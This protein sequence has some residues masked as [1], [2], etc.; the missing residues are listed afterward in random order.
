MRRACLPA[1]LLA[2]ILVA[3][4][5][6]DAATRYDPSLRF[7]VLRTAH[8]VI[9]FHQGEDR[10]ARRLASIAETTRTRLSER[11]GLPAPARTHVVL[12][13]Q[14][15]NSNGWATPVPY[16][17]IEITAAPPL[18]ESWLGNSDDWL[19]LAFAHEYTH[20][21]H[22]DRAEGGM[23]LL[24]A[25]LGR[26]PVTFPN[27]FLP[28]WQIEGLPT[29]AESAMT[30]RGRLGAGDFANVMDQAARRGRFPSIDRASGGLVS[31][32]GGTAPYLYGGFF[33]AYLADRYGESRF[34]EL[35]RRTAGRLPFFGGAAFNRTYGTSAKDAW[36]DFAR[37]RT[38]TAARA[39]GD[40]VPLT[41][42]THHG[43]AVEAPRFA[44]PMSGDA[45]SDEVW[46]G[47][48]TPDGFPGLHRVSLDTGRSRRVADRYLG[49]GLSVSD[50][51]V[52]FDQ[53]EV[54]RAVSLVGDLYALDRV[55]GRTWRLTRGARMSSPDVS[56]D[57]RHL[58]VV[59]SQ[60]GGRALAV[61]VLH[62][63]S[64]PNA[65]PAPD[66]AP[67]V[68][69]VEPG[70]QYGGPRWSPDGARL[71]AERQRADGTSEIVI[72]DP[73]TL[74]VHVVVSS[75]RDRNVTPT[76][77]PDG[78]SIVFAATRDSDP[79]QLYRVDIPAPHATTA[80]AP[81]RLFAT[82]H[83]ATAPALSPDGRTVVFVGVTDRGDDL[84]AARLP[85]TEEGPAAAAVAAPIPAPAPTDHDAVPAND[86]PDSP[87][88]RYS[89]WPTL[90]PRAWMPLVQAD[91]DRWQL[92]ASVG[93]GDVLGRHFYDARVLW[94]LSGNANLAGPGSGRR[95]D[96]GVDYAYDR[97]RPTLFVSAADTTTP[98]LDQV[99]APGL[100]PENLEQREREA[101]FGIY[102]PLRRV[103]YSMSWMASLDLVENTL[104]SSTFASV[105]TRNAVRLAA[106]GTSARVYG[107]SISPEGG[108]S[109]VAT[110]EAVSPALGAD[111]QAQAGTVDIRGYLPIGPPHAVLAVRAAAGVSTGDVSVRRFF[112]L[113]GSGPRPADFE[114]GRRA[115]GLLRGFPLDSFVGSSLA[116]LNV[117]YRAPLWRVER[118]VRTWP[119]FL[120]VLHGAVFADAGSTWIG[121]RARG[122]LRTSLG[123]EL[124]VDLTLGYGF[125][126]TLAAGSAWTRDP[127]GQRPGGGAVFVRLGRAF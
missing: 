57:G 16:D 56:P 24:R 126:L 1:C 12:V 19:E 112:S 14:T 8:F 113:G 42:L 92:G 106:A 102:L 47:V 2:A 3:G 79:F 18:P 68:T 45:P 116:V 82:G 31:W 20:I 105:T 93:G 37:D 117:D 100:P 49:N 119:V 39:R 66:A 44:P 17:T 107:Y 32:P 7:R 29:Y 21:L 77:S 75:R 70:G 41:Q 51:W 55:T 64:A 6:A 63:P 90:T 59:V 33:H 9:Y 38:G 26:S 88:E 46:Y 13:D 96:W 34:G 85:D 103:R 30:G 76:W 124:S 4:E 67:A 69:L 121:T 81:V 83:G 53:L 89:P 125:P 58:A 11:F 86:Q 71:T 72:I 54:S 115:L 73:A 78:R 98:L 118:G 52:Y 48:R 97:W 62:D 28:A 5:A 122:P 108:L 91:G 10:L 15:D 95:P 111:G 22:L 65:P 109:A 99:L 50:R 101:A 87:D 80:P 23:R 35:A 25:V 60:P 110:F 61:L 40:A 120:N 104:R 36:A 74:D 27:L 114:F 84:F 43:F 123:A 127:S 94:P